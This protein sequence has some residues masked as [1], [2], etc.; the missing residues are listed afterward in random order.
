MAGKLQPKTRSA[1][2]TKAAILLSAGELFAKKG[3]VGASM[4][5]LAESL[6][7]SKAAI[8]HHF[9]NKESILRTL[10][11]SLSDDFEKLLMEAETSP[12]KSFDRGK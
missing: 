3:Y 2:R 4:S 1:S 10:V 6:D 7:I 9:E 8:Y 11:N 5:D 12:A